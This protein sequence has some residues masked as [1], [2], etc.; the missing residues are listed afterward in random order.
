MEFDEFLE[1]ATPLLGLQWRPF[2]K[3]RSRRVD[4]LVV[5]FLI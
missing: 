4:N 3:E 2:Q 5:S 1:E